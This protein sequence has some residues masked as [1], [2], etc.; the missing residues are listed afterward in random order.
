MIKFN[1]L[2]LKRA[3]V[4]VNQTCL[5]GIRFREKVSELDFEV[6]KIIN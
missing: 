1:N 4:Y 3:S 2:L 6:S 5:I